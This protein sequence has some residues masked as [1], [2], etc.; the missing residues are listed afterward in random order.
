MAEYLR[1]ILENLEPVRVADSALS[2]SGQTS[3][4]RYIPGSTI[5]GLIVSAFAKKIDFEKIKPL[6]FSHPMAYLNAYL[7]VEGQALIPSPKGFYENKQIA[8]G[9]K[10]IQNAVIDGEIPEG[11]KRASLGSYCSL[12]ENRIQYSNVKT[13]SDMKILINP[14]KHQK[15]NVFRL[16]MLAPGQQFEGYIRLSGTESVDNEI[17]NLLAEGKIIRIGNA[18]TSGLG[19]CKVVCAETV[20][21]PRTEGEP[22]QAV[23]ECYMMLL[24]D[25]VMRNEE[26]EYC[27]LHLPELENRMGVTDLKIVYAAT[28]TRAIYGYNRTWESKRPSITAYEAG[29]VFHFTYS[30]TFDEEHMQKL[31]DEGIGIRRN[32]GMGRIRFL[33]EYEK[34]NR[35]ILRK[36]AAETVQKKEIEII[37]MTAEE[38]ETLLVAAKSYLRDRIQTAMEK[39]VLDH[40]LNKARVKNSQLGQIESRL[41]RYRYNP[42][43]A[44]QD[45][46]GFFA[47]AEEKE[48][49][50][51]VQKDRASIA[52]ISAQV[53]KILNAPLKTTLDQEWE[54]PDRIMGIPVEELLSKKEEEQYK[55]DLLIQMIR[56]DRKKEG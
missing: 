41:L 44:K 6:L 11:W 53:Q 33:N 34:I 38:K 28:S 54:I 56:F 12:T 15:R 1:Y 10:E 45:L 2:Q 21:K 55:L 37:V 50:Q 35:K 3:A 14:G 30:G 4:V 31:C 52:V 32:E 46:E 16:E 18:R 49:K 26:G 24:S 51:K 7:H 17:Q 19:K 25:T 22:F 40:E 13:T 39:Y 20:D 29:S 36:T 27:G 48:E 42:E 43:N 47:H 8:E 9:E 5:R 23:G